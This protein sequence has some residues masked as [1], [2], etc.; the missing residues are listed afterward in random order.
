MFQVVEWLFEAADEGFYAQL[1]FARE[2]KRAILWLPG[3]KPATQS[4]AERAA[5]QCSLVGCTQ[6]AYP[7]PFLAMDAPENRECEV[8]WVGIDVDG[9]DN[10]MLLSDLI[11]RLGEACPTASLRLSCGGEG[12]H[13][14]FRLARPVRCSPAS[15][16]RIVKQ[17]TAGPVAA[18]EALGVKVCKADRRI[19]WL[20]GGKNE[21]VRQTEA[22]IDAHLA[23]FQSQLAAPPPPPVAPAGG[24][25]PGVAAWVARFQQAGV[26]PAQVAPHNLIYVGSAVDVLKAHNQKVVTKSR[27]SGNGQVNGYID[28]SRDRISLWTF[29]DGHQCWSFVEVD[30]V[31]SDFLGGES[32]GD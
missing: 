14:L 13:V 32:G 29:C 18:I 1:G 5:G 10:A 27:C 2:D 11:L 3:R 4:R 16:N 23:I 22:K 24:F 25:E 31:I 26:L 6:L 17:I 12:V 28:V 30:S 20:W 7:A 19:F 9:D 21:W 8:C 15:A